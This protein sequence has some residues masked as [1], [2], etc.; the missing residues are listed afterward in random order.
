ML[1]IGNTEI[2]YADRQARLT[3]EAGHEMYFSE[4]AAQRLEKALRDTEKWARADEHLRVIGCYPADREAEERLL[5][6]RG[7]IISLALEGTVLSLRWD[8]G[9]ARWELREQAIGDAEDQFLAGH[10]LGYLNAAM[11]AAFAG[12]VDAVGLPSA[13]ADADRIQWEG[14]RKPEFLR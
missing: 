3:L 9:L 14:Q 4:A 10:P 11:G 13:D 8:A 5:A 1:K 2:E 7:L 12:L 6:E